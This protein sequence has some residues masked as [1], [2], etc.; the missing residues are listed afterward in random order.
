MNVKMISFV[1]YFRTN[2]NAR[3]TRGSVTIILLLVVTR[4]NCHRC[5]HSSFL[6]SES[7]ESEC[8]TLTM[9]FC[10]M[11]TLGALVEQVVQAA[12]AAGATGATGAAFSCMRR[13]FSAFSSSTL[14][15]SASSA[16]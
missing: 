3:L 6:D 10:S 4:T 11:V 9:V 8:A 14:W 12:G 1:K 15:A 2:I 5:A 16:A 13:A 7:E